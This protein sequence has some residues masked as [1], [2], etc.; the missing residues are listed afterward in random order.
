MSGKSEHP[1]LASYI[2]GL[3]SQDVLNTAHAVTTGHTPINYGQ[4][5]MPLFLEEGW[6]L[7]A[8]APMLDYS[9]FMP[10]H[11]MIGPYNALVYKGIQA[12]E[13]G[14]LDPADAAAFVVEEM[15]GELGDELVV[16]D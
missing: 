5:A 1:E 16:L 11:A 2:V 15:Q 8:G 10:N 7:R 6:A 4:T 3:A 9:S 13:T 12:V 14:K